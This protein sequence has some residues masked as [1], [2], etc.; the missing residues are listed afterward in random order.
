MGIPERIR[1]HML[2]KKPASREMNRGKKAAYTGNEVSEFTGRERTPTDE[3]TQD[4]TPL[5]VEGDAA[6]IGRQVR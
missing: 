3:A 6:V 2:G 1:K 4:R 5:F